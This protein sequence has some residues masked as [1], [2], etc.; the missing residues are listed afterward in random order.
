ML[1]QV[2]TRAVRHEATK[3]R[4]L[5]A[6]WRLARRDG[7]Q[8]FSLR[9]LA[10][11][12]GMRA[13]SLYS[14]FDSKFALYDAM[15]A[16]GNQDFLKAIHP[17]PDPGDFER[18]LKQWSRRL[19]DVGSSDPVRYQLLFQRTIPGF[20]PSPES[21]AVATEVF[22]TC[23]L[24]FA[25]VGITDPRWFDLWTAIFSGLESQQIANDPG[26]DRWERLVDEAVEMFLNHVGYK[27]K[28]GRKR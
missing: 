22:E 2:D 14:Y 11:A 20:E 21:Y 7:L 5:K 8:G 25:E 23:R 13:P 12:V 27:P 26:G 3:E 9:E 4:I 19:L 16:Q 6:A 1:E 24:V 18:T 17:L 10:K 28:K 15:F